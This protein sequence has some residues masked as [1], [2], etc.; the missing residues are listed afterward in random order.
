MQSMVIVTGFS[1]MKSFMLGSLLL[2][3]FN[4]YCSTTDT[5]L[6]E[7]QL[8]LEELLHKRFYQKK[9]VLFELC[10]HGV[11]AWHTGEDNVSLEHEARESF[12]TLKDK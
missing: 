6:H 3:D 7:F 8:L 4:I 5:L 1:V 2:P 12:H 9:L 11:P 10:S